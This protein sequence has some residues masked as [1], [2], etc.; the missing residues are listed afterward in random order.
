MGIGMPEVAGAPLVR[1]GQLAV[2]P[3][4]AQA[5]NPPT[6]KVA[7]PRTSIAA[8]DPLPSPQAALRK[9]SK[10]GGTQGSKDDR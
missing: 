9:R 7:N 5:V 1:A 10:P 2:L 3:D 4:I 6:T 8:S